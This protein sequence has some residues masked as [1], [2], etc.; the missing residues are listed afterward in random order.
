MNTD[1]IR[2]LSEEWTNNPELHE[3]FKDD[4]VKFIES[5][6][7]ELDDIEKTKFAEWHDLTDRDIED[8][9]NK[10]NC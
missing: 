3:K 5:W 8:R 2:K 10:G 1:D 4:P 9:I 6:G 7:C